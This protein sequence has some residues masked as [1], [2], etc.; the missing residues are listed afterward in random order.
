MKE[1]RNSRVWGEQGVSIHLGAPPSATG[2]HTQCGVGTPPPQ[3]GE[4]MCSRKTSGG[5]AVSRSWTGL[6]EVRGCHGDACDLW[7]VH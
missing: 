3:G 7:C 4:G 5:D 6:Q 2:G 1:G